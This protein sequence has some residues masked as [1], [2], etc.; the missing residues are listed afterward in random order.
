MGYR[1]GDWSAGDWLGMASMMLIFWG[2]LIT[3]VVWALRSRRRGGQGDGERGATP[4]IVLAG[5]FA[6][7]E[8][9]EDEYQRHRALLHSATSPTSGGKSEPGDA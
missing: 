9:G 5:R 7:G 6:R 1:D 3:L 8:L 4:D 2:L